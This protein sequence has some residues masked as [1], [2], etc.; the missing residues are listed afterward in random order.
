VVTPP[1][2]SLWKR[3]WAMLAPHDEA[4]RVWG[5]RTRQDCP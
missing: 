4:Q 1:A 2:Q 3:I 5:E